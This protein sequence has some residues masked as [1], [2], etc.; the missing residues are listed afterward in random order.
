MHRHL[1]RCSRHPMPK[2]PVIEVTQPV[3]PLVGPD[4]LL[5]TR[6]VGEAI[7]TNPAPSERAP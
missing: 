6:I 5:G 1:S 4:K 3:T 2:V 7:M